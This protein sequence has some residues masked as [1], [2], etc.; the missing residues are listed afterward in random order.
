MGFLVSRK[1]RTVQWSTN[2]DGCV[3]LVCP[4]V[5]YGSILDIS[6]VASRSPGTKVMN[7]RQ[8]KARPG[9]AASG[10]ESG[11]PHNGAMKNPWPFVDI[12][13]GLE[14]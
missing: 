12:T 8:L 11:W 6:D 10:I 3:M 5:A 13:H 7:V 4:R 1:I 9:P 2:G 14:E